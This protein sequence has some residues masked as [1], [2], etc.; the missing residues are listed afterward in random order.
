M[1]DKTSV[2]IDRT[3]PVYEQCFSFT[4]ILTVRN[5]FVSIQGIGQVSL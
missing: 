5:L 3:A 1:D 4:F 2:P